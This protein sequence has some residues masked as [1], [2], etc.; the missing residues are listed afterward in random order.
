[1]SVTGVGALVLIPWTIYL[2]VTLRDRHRVTQWGTAWVGF[3]ILLVVM[4]ALSAWAA[5]RRR[6]VAVVF[7]TAAAVLLLIDAWFDVMLSWGTR[8]QTSA[9]VT[10]FA[11]EIPLCILFVLSVRKALLRI[12]ETVADLRGE[13]RPERSLLSRRMPMALGPVRRSDGSDIQ[14]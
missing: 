3:D 12:G 7:L 5:W 11:F 13:T 1:M 8:E 4:L 2:S 6:L 10:A 14:T 9:L